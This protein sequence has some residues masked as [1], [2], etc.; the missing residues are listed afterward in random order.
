[1]RI[2]LDTNILARANPSA[3]GPARQVLV[4]IAESVEHVLIVSAFLLRELERVL[5]YPR[6]KRI[7]PLDVDEI[8]EY[9]QALESFA[10]LVQ[11]QVPADWPHLLADPGDDPV[12]QAALTARADV[13]CTL[14]RHFYT[15]AV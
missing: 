5:G 10:E 4:E 3:S 11:P 9:V 6:L 2:V 8:A 7:W 12:L 13:L 14:D 15:E 1:M